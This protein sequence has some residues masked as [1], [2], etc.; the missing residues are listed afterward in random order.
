MKKQLV[1]DMS[2]LDMEGDILDVA[3][4]NTGIIYDIS[5]E[6]EQKFPISSK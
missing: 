1:I 6:I 2:D 5:K 3:K 4:E